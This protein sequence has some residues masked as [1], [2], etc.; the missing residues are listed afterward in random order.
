MSSQYITERPAK[1]FKD[2][3]LSVIYSAMRV[4]REFHDAFGHPVRT[5]PLIPSPDRV[6]L[7]QNLINEEWNE[8]QEALIKGD[9]IGFTDG[10]CDLLYVVLG[11]MVEFGIP[12]MVFDEVHW[13]NMTKL[14]EDGKPILR[15]DG[16]SMKGPN[17]KPPNLA[18]IL[19]HAGWVNPH[20]P[21]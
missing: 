5:I 1:V 20:K 10:I 8:A 16:K 7:R 21:E 11:T 4:M 6:A 14:G 19:E 2:E 13:S 18:A 17:F 12:C 3:S 15:A 9:L